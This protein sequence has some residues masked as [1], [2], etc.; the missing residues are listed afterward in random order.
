M[1][2]LMAGVLLGILVAITMVVLVSMVERYV[3]ESDNITSKPSTDDAVEFSE[4][5]RPPSEENS[6]SG[7]PQ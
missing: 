5:H 6:S 7:I 2:E 1:I 3:H 4:T